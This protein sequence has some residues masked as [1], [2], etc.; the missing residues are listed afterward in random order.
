MPYIS[1]QPTVA[2]NSHFVDLT[3]SEREELGGIE[4]RSLKSLAMIL[5]TYY[6]TL[7]AISI[8]GLTPWILHTDRW[9]QVVDDAGQSRTWWGFF[10]GLSA[11]NDVGFTLTP[12]SML[13]FQAAVWPLLLMSL[14]IIFGNTGFPVLL[15]FIIFVS[16]KFVP[17][18]S[19][20]WEELRF[21]L[22]HPRRCFTLLFPSNATWW[23]FWIL[24]LLNGID[25]LFFIILD[26]GSEVVTGLPPGIRV[27]DGVF[28]AASTRTAGFA[29]VNLAALHPGVQISY[30]IMMYISIFPIAISVRRTNVYEE[31]SLGIWS[32]ADNDEDPQSYVGSHI[33]RQLSFD[34]WFVAL[35]WFIIAVAEGGQLKDPEK[36]DFT[37]FSVLFEIISAYGTVGLS[38]GYPNSNTSFCA[39]FGTIGKLI[40]IAMMVRGRHRG[41]PYELDKAILLPSESLHQRE[42]EEAHRMAARRSSFGTA[43]GNDDDHDGNGNGSGLARVGTAGSSKSQGLKKRS[44]RASHVVSQLLHPGP[45][46]PRYIHKRPTMERENPMSGGLGSVEERRGNGNALGNGFGGDAARKVNTFHVGPGRGVASPPKGMDRRRKMSI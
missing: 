31:R 45:V 14:M 26:F 29:V 24:V 40:V 6:W 4:Y 9:G 20:I 32:D 30:M 3:E 44:R 12:D 34:L 27:L 13:S 8:I 37:L 11:F 38:L 41:L 17:S 46:M 16:S 10:T 21:L 35:G 15:R 25:L 39:Q 19:G 5:V 1:F 43:R 22:D 7:M 2:R 33:R 23:L 42:M 18:G 28:Q 36:P